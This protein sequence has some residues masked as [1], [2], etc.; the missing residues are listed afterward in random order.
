MT[1]G[2]LLDDFEITLASLWD[3]DDHEIDDD[4][5]EIDDD[6]HEI[7]VHENDAHEIDADDADDDDDD[8][9]DDADHGGMGDDAADDYA[10][11]YDTLGSLRITLVVCL[12]ISAG[13]ATKAK[14]L[15]TYWL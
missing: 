8:D 6:A 10:D 11:I 1:F 9:D 15:K 4:V 5:H 12:R 3:H 2:W 14:M 13:F 7:D